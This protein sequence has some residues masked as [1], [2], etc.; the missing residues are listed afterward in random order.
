MSR[1]PMAEVTG[2]LG[3]LPDEDIARS[4]PM[5]PRHGRAVAR[6]RTPQASAALQR[7]AGPGAMRPAADSVRRRRRSGERGAA[8]YASACAVC[9]D[10]G[11]PL[12]FGGLTFALST[13]V[14]APDPQNIVNV[15]LFGLPA[16]D[17]EA[18][19]IMPGF[20]G[21]L[22]RMQHVARCSTTCASASATQPAWDDARSGRGDAERRTQG[23]DLPHRTASSRRPPMSAR[24][25]ETWR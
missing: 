17:G 25:T 15:T 7:R 10:S 16:A 11:R 4:R 22:N 12:P 2:N 1:G 24:R 9:H 20:A 18:S 14:N 21:V 23:A 3:P 19:S 6:A 13:A 8:I 5:S